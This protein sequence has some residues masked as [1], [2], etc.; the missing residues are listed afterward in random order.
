MA[1]INLSNIKKIEKQRNTLHDKVY[2]TYTIF[3]M[4]GSKYI[5]IDTYGRIDRENPE[6]LSQS[7]QLDRETAKY[8]VNL[9]TQ[10]F[11]LK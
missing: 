10:E 5:Q 8:L 4:E 9:L 7:I 6:K 11:N 1:Q 2:T 3:E